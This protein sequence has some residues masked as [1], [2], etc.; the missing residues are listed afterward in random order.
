MKKINFAAVVLFLFSQTTFAVDAACEAKAAEK[1]LA[2]AAKNS[3]IKKCDKDAKISAAKAS[4]D[5]KAAEKSLKG[6][7]KNSFTKK[8]VTDA[9]K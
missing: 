2:G 1:K 9:S 8:C 5:A 6:A 7:A 3:F 4:C